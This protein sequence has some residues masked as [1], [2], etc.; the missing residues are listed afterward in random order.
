MLKHWKSRVSALTLIC[1]NGFLRIKVR[2]KNLRPAGHPGRARLS[3]LESRFPI[4]RPGRLWK[5]LGQSGRTQ[6]RTDWPV[7]NTVKY[8][9]IAHF[10]IAQPAGPPARLSPH[11]NCQNGNH[12]LHMQPFIPTSQRGLNFSRNEILRKNGIFKEM[13]ACKTGPK[14]SSVQKNFPR[15]LC[16][17][18][19]YNSHLLFSAI[20]TYPK[21]KAQDQKPEI[22]LR[23]QIAKGVTP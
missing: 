6:S 4:V 9:N 2:V 12:Y 21:D 18:L 13:V 7:G 5:S 1:R 3:F 8:R 20:I 22:D 23:S 17:R 19:S 14:G 16:P 11:Y 10:F 15:K